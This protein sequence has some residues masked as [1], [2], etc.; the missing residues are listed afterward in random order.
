V[1]TGL[2]SVKPDAT[3]HGGKATPRGRE[4][5]NPRPAL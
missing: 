2:T 3:G 5:A 1:N 4:G